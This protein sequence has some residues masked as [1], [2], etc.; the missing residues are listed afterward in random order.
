MTTVPQSWTD[1]LH[2]IQKICPSAV[3]A[4][5]ALRDL[6]HGIAVKD[7]DIFIRAGSN[8]EAVGLNEL[9]GGQPMTDPDTQMYPASMQEIQ[10]VVDLDDER[11]LIQNET[12]LPVQLIFIN[13]D[14]RF[15]CK[16]VDF[17]LCKTSYDGRELYFSSEY[18]IDK[19]SK[20]MTLQRCDNEQALSRSVAR[21]ARWK[22][23][24]PEH[25]FVLGCHI[26]MGTDNN[27]VDF[28]VP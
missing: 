18:Q 13:W 25:E 3:I 2:Q 6:D 5:G 19:D 24:Y 15:I 1:L 7:L 26:D 21:F 11:D 12:G 28:G 14:T 9:I 17:G 16:R 27:R 4:G 20:S 8:D 10:L 23:R 22:P